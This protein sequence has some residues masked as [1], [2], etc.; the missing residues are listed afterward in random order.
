MKNIL[1]SLTFIFALASFIY[2]A[3]KPSSSDSEKSK[4]VWI[5]TGKHSECYHK[6]KSCKGLGSCKASIKEVSLEEAERMKRR[7]CK[8]C[9]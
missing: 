4:T 8:L 1:I 7:P 3:D 6:S 5:C 9:Y 2:K